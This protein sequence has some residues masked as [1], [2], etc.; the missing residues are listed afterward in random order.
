M[1]LLRIEMPAGVPLVSRRTSKTEN[2]RRSSGS[3]PSRGLTMTNCPGVA[4]AA[5]RGAL[6]ARTLYS[7]DSGV[8][9]VT[10][11]AT[12]KGDIAA[13]YFANRCEVLG[14][15]CEVH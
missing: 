7:G 9:D 12:S 4:A 1:R 8:L 15:R 13:V 10:S 5:M 11:A 3:C 6:S 2:G 14:A